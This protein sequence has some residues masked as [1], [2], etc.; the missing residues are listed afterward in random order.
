MPQLP[1]VGWLHRCEDCDIITSRLTTCKYKRKTHHLYICLTC[2]QN[3]VIW[4]SNEFKQVIVE[5]ETIGQQ[6]L[7]VIK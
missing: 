3:F 6:I 4:L 2:R 7:K 1:K 5:S